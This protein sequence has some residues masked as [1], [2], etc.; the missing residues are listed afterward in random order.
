NM[1]P[2]TRHIGTFLKIEGRGEVIRQ[3]LTPNLM[4]TCGQ[5]RIIN[6]IFDRV[7]PSIAQ[8]IVAVLLDDE[9]VRS[10]LFEIDVATHFFARGL[11]VQF[12]DVE[13]S[14][15]FDLLVSKGQRE[16]EIECKTK[17]AD[18]GRKIV[19]ANF[20]LLC[21]VL[22]AELSPITKS[23]AILFRC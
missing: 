17:S 12:V 23:F 1:N 19:R 4:K 7:T 13:G 15:R 6:A 8:K 14:D 20:Y 16:L 3:Y 9:T 11:D 22:V 21:D 10:F 18:A 5:L 2:L